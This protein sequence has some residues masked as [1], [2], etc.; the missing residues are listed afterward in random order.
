[1]AQSAVAPTAK[2]EIVDPKKAL[3]K[4]ASIVA[5]E[6]SWGETT[7]AEHLASIGKKPTNDP[8]ESPFAALTQDTTT[9]N[10]WSCARNSCIRNWSSTNEW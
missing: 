4:Y 9:S 3:S 10:F 5:G 7:E 2:K 1:M 6:Y 8:A